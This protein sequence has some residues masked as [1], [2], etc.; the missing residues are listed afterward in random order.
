M[1]KGLFVMK[2]VPF[3]SGVHPKGNKAFS[4]DEPICKI[5]PG[6]ILVF[7]MSQHIGAPATPVV[8]AGDAVLVGTK[9]ADAASFVSSPIHSSVS[10]IVKNVEN[11]RMPDGKLSECVVIENDH[12]YTAV[13]NYGKENDLDA[14]SVDEI[15]KIISDSGIVGLGGAGFPTGVKIAPKNS[16]YIDYVI[17]NGA[18]CEP[19]LTSDYRVVIEK[20]EN[21]IDGLSIALRLFPNAEGVIA[22]EDNKPDA[23]SVMQEKT[24]K[25]PRISV[26]SLKTKYPQG[27]ERRLIAS[28][29]GRKINSH[30]LPADAGVVVLNAST[31]CAIYDAVFKNIPLVR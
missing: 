26:Q 11:R 22:I 31:A 19:Y 14:M 25:Y 4:A 6:D 17:I 16:E 13:E 28:I 8:K 18:E 2:K 12:N 27:A 23:I 1:S 30:L 20:T 29:T 7:P 15:K 5:E 9:I 10:G 3:R 21:V 24:Q